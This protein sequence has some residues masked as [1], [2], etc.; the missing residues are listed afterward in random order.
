MGDDH[1][2]GKRGNNWFADVIV[3]ATKFYERFLGLSWAAELPELE[4]YII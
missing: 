4:T 3:L 1:Q 2:G